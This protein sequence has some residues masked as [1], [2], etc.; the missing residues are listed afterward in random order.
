MPFAGDGRE[1]KVR[2]EGPLA[3]NAIPLILNSALAGLERFPSE[4]NCR[5]FPNWRVHD[6]CSPPR[7]GGGGDG[8]IGRSS[9]AGG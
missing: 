1:L 9:R 2:V 3:F 5:G 8:A 4:M 6:L 7:E